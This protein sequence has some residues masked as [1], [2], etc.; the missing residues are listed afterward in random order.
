[1]VCQLLISLHGLKYALR[2][3]Y[4]NMDSFF[5]ASQFTR[6]H[7]N[8]T[9]YI[10]HRG[11]DLLIHVLYVDDLIIIG[12]LV[13]MIQGVQKSLRENF[14]MLDLGLLHY[15]LGL[16]VVQSSDGIPILQQ[17]Y[18]LDMLRRFSM[19]NYKPAPMPFQSGV[20]LSTTCS[21]PIVDSTLYR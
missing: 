16:Q 3:W 21:T 6:C 13:S 2:A 11:G 10:Q 20:V 14:E 12:S 4:D 17:K 5:L 19:L 15:F 8:P 1:M 9:I 7:S 18:A